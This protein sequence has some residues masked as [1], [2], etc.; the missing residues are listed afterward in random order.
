M[1]EHED[2]KLSLPDFVAKHNL[3]KP[4]E[5]PAAMG[6]SPG[7]S[8][9]KIRQKWREYYAGERAR[10]TGQPSTEMTARNTSGCR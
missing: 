1:S 6:I 10:I 4:S 7:A 9:K 5:F 3:L 2:S 8:M